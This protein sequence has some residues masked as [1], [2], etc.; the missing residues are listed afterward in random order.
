MVIYTNLTFDLRITESL[1]SEVISCY[2][3]GADTQV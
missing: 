3:Y 2:L 1:I